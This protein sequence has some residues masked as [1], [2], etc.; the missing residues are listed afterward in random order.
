MN[1]KTPSL[2][3]FFVAGISYRNAS[4]EVR[5]RYSISAQQY[6]N[7]LACAASYGIEE[8]FVL[9]TCNRTEIYAFAKDEAQVIELLCSETSASK[10]EFIKLASIK[11]AHEAVRHLYD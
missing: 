11:N 10:E 9:S 6:E 3:N 4:A 7:I 2:Q 1:S 8:L 5:G